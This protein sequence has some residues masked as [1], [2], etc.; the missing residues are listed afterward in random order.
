VWFFLFNRICDP[1]FHIWKLLYL[2]SLHE[3]WSD[4][5][6]EVIFDFCIFNSIL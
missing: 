6:V 5:C 1:D 2:W 3:V 4:E